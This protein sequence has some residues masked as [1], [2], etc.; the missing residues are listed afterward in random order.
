MTWYRK[1]PKTFY[2]N[3]GRS[4]ATLAHARDLMLSLPQTQQAT[5][6]WLEAGEVLVE[7]AYRNKMAALSDVA[8][9]FSTAL[10]A[11]GL[12]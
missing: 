8:L 2:L 9:G 12:I 10:E 5:I 3:D 4:I 6:H 11:E 7:A 1:F